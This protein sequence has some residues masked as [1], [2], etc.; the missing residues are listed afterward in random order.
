MCFSLYWIYACEGKKDDVFKLNYSFVLFIFFLP[1]LYG[2][3]VMLFSHQQAL[4]FGAHYLVANGF[5]FLVCKTDGNSTASW[6][7]WQVKWVNIYKGLRLVSILIAVQTPAMPVSSPWPS[8]SFP[9]V[10]SPFLPPG[11]SGCYYLYWDHSLHLTGFYSTPSL[12]LDWQLR[13][14]QCLPGTVAGQ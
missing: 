14:V 5:S 6:G 3:W 7:C 1:C 13:A 9:N 2:P 4:W 12:I 10:L 11:L 8:F